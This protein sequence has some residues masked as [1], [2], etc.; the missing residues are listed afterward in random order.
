M[1]YSL[2]DWVSNEDDVVVEKR[3]RELK[4]GERDGGCFCER[5]GIAESKDVVFDFEGQEGY[6]RRG[7]IHLGL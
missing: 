5:R 1:G 4:K 6:N 3:S 7:K 2:E